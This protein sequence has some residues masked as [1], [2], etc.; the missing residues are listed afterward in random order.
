MPVDAAVWTALAALT[1]YDLL[2]EVHA[3]FLRAG[4]DVITANTFAT[5]RFV[6]AAAGQAENF[7]LVNELSIAAVRDAKRFQHSGAAV[8]GSI[9]CLPP[10]FDWRA[11]PDEKTARAAFHEIAD[12]LASLGVDLLMLE[13]LQDDEHAAWALEAALATGLPV[14]LGFSCRRGEDRGTLVG[15][16][17]PHRPIDDWLSRCLDR[18]LAAVNVM[19]TPIDAIEPALELLEKLW[20]GPI[21]VYPEVGSFDAATRTR[22]ANVEPRQLAREAEQWLARGVEIIGGCCGANPSHIRALRELSMPQD[23]ERSSRR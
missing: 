12:K 5:N 19:H 14:W 15:F 9:S 13:M 3:D 10:N 4:A 2:V 6:L 16:D 7:D 17:P 18:D 11:Y 21:G 20:Q 23:D 22:S 1:H 8:A